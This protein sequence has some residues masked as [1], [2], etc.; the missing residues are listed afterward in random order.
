M[1]REDTFWRRVAAVLLLLITLAVIANLIQPD[2]VPPQLTLLLF[3]S[4]L[5]LAVGYSIIN[6]ESSPVR[7]EPLEEARFRKRQYVIGL[8][9]SMVL[10]LSLF[11]E[12]VRNSTLAWLFGPIIVLPVILI[13]R[14]RIKRGSI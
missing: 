10:A 12:E 14:E 1:I 5:A 9:F 4:L 7:L 11:V 6:P 2:T 3:G 13:V 8:V